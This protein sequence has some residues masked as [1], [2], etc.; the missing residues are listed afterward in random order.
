[1]NT[2]GNNKD[3]GAFEKKTITSLVEKSLGNSMTKVNSNS[4]NDDC[5][6]NGNLLKK[7]NQNI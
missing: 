1:M 2:S 3:N 5:L 6:N 7:I 4:G